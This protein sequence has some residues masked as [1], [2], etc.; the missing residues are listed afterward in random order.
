MQTTQLIEIATGGITDLET[1]Q[2]ILDDNASRIA[3]KREANDVGFLVGL[4]SELSN[5]VNPFMKGP[6][7][8]AFDLGQTEAQLDLDSS[9]VATT[10]MIRTRRRPMRLRPLDQLLHR[11][12]P[13]S[14]DLP[15]LGCFLYSFS[16]QAL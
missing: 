15:A 5:D 3:T 13:P 7:A 8:V 11:S 9:T 6:L 4:N 14:C 2:N 10:M 12:N 16:L 1:I